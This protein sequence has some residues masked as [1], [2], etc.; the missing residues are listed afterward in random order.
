MVCLSR[1]PRPSLATRGACRRSS[2]T[3][4]LRWSGQDHFDWRSGCAESVERPVL[5]ADLAVS[6]AVS[7]ET[8]VAV[9]LNEAVRECS[10]SVVLAKVV[11]NC[12]FGGHGRGFVGWPLTI[13]SNDHAAQLR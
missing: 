4:T 9:E 6:M 1:P 8:P 7:A 5:T 10:A 11:K 2:A 12:G 3:C 13:G